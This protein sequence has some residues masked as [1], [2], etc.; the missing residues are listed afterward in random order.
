MTHVTENRI[1]LC[2]P[3]LTF[4]TQIYYP[5]LIKLFVLYA[6]TCKIFKY[7]KLTLYSQIH[8]PLS[9]YLYSGKRKLDTDTTEPEGIVVVCGD[10][11]TE[12]NFE[13]CLRSAKAAATAIGKHYSH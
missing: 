8:Y 13:G 2:E 12:S 7:D 4:S 11:F 9:L 5:I 3:T 10:A 1:S 6:H